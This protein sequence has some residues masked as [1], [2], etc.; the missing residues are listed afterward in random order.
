ML[1]SRRA[2]NAPSYLGFDD[3]QGVRLRALGGTL[4]ERMRGQLP[5][6]I[7][8][9][10][11]AMR[12]TVGAG[13]DACNALIHRT[14]DRLLVVEL[15]RSGPPA[16]MSDV[17]EGAVQSIVGATALQTLCDESAR[18]FRELTGY[19]RVMVYRFDEAGHGEVFSE[20]KAHELEAFLG[21]RYPASDIP[22]IARRLYERNRVRVLAD[23]NYEPAALFPRLS[24]ISGRDLDMSLCFLRSVSPIHLQY[25][26]NMGVAGT[27][28]VSL[29]VG[30]RLWG[31]VSCHHYS[32]RLLHFEMRAVCE[33]LAEVIGTRIA[34]LESFARG[35]GEL[36]ARR[37]EQRMV[38]SVSRNGDWR[39]ALFD[40]S[41][42]LLL[43]LGANGAALIFENDVIATGDVPGTDQIREIAH[44]VGPKLK[45]GVF[46]TSSLGI[47]E[48]VFAPLAG[49]ASGVVAAPISPHDDEML[50]WFRSERVRT[51]TWG[52]NPFKTPSMEDDPSELSPRRSFAQWHQIVEGTSDPWTEAEL[53]AARLI[54]ASITDVI[55]QF[56]AVRILIAQDQLQHVLRQVRSSDQQVV[57]ADARGFVIE[58]NAA[59]SEMLAIKNGALRR[60]DELPNYFAEP[61]QARRNL[62]A[63]VSQHRPW[64]GEAVVENARG[65]PKTVLVR[66]DPVFAAP[67]RVLGFVLLLADLTERKAAES[68]RR[69]FQDGIVLSHRKVSGAG[70][71]PRN[72]AV[73]NLMSSVIENAQ[74][75]AL[76]ITDGTDL[77]EVPNLL[78]SVRASVART[79]EVLEQLAFDDGRAAREARSKGLS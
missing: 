4:W 78:E 68:A 17:L 39:G 43:P 59:F 26:K 77:S 18:I 40:Q 73:Q 53:A 15:E 58:S 44:W 74:L 66:A 16:S 52:G 50:I 42:P 57:V 37:L 49:V 19:D 3:L 51:V 7:R 76:E 36:A 60:I 2:S 75:A 61:D 25:L 38:E 30:G 23:V 27:L 67:D 31:L 54:G 29:M 46:S 35:Q 6:S 13:T 79:A 72:I 8:A 47:D 28:V 45:A 11:A 65:E 70:D 24:P 56:R 64:R 33:L 48:P 20:T 63:L 10:P 9:I 71:A 62:K 14:P 55:V 41:R 5:E 12:C 21:N 34:A 22:Q 1:S 32:P 69:R